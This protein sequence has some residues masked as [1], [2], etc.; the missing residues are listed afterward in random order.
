M[1]KK[2]KKNLIRLTVQIFFLALIILISFNHFR[3]EQGLAPLLI[4]SPSLH[5][6]CPFGGVVTIYNYFTEGAFVQNIQQSSV[7]LMWLVLG[8][9]LLF[10]P[11]FCGWIC[12]FGTV[13]EFVG[14]IGRKIFKKRYNNF[15][16]FKLDKLLKYLRYV[17]LLLVVIL[18]ATSGK[19]LFSNVDPYFALFNI[20]SSEVTRLS[21]LVLGLIL[22]GSLFVERPWCKYLCPFGAL[23]GIF[24]FFRIVKLKRNEK[25]CI[26]CKVCDRV[27][28]MNIDISTS[29]VITDHQCIS[30][31]LCTDEMACPVSNSLNFSVLERK[32][33]K[34][35]SKEDS[36]AKIKESISGGGK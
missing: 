31:L 33:P 19:L 9:T 11:V 13:E 2:Q 34:E 12:P 17:I 6:V 15:I 27:C 30:C 1:A 26:N 25:T 29:K 32:N 3:N 7:T 20:W 22:I 8:L 36:G 18:T 16:P 28:P 21:L 4:G 5:A 24:N 23:L 14:K 10:G 35:D